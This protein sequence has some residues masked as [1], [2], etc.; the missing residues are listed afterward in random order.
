MS[1][2]YMWELLNVTSLSFTQNSRPRLINLWLRF[3]NYYTCLHPTE[4]REHKFQNSLLCHLKH[5][6]CRKSFSLSTQAYLQKSLSLSQSNRKTNLSSS[7]SQ[8]W[9]QR[10]HHLLLLK[11]PSR[12]LKALLSTGNFYMNKLRST[13]RTWWTWSSNPGS[14]HSWHNT[15]MCFQLKLR[16]FGRL[17]H[18]Q[19]TRSPFLVKFLYPR[20]SLQRNLSYLL[21]PLPRTSICLWGWGIGL[22]Y[23]ETD[24]GSMDNHECVRRCSLHSI[25]R[26]E[27][28]GVQISA[29]G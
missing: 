26:E 15:P 27:R 11:L 2:L 25:L 24:Q 17:L 28:P 10:N 1:N 18:F 22:C 7:F 9:H 20:R 3:N 29:I 12:W 19:R 6:L 14:N 5:K 16:P 23:F 21:P 13:W 4:T 8:K